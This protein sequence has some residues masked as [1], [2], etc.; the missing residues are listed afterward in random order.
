MASMSSS[1]N[2]S[3]ITHDAYVFKKT[4]ARRGMVFGTWDKG[5]IGRTESN[6]DFTA[7][8]DMLPR[9]GWDGRI[10]FIRHGNKPPVEDE[11]RPNAEDENGG[12]E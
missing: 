10:R 11:P 5:G 2:K 4:G 8:I 1:N 9:C 12:D 3:S 7:L 6:G